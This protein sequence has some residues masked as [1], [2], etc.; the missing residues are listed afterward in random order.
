MK[1]RGARMNSKEKIHEKFFADIWKLQNFE[2][3]INDLLKSKE[4]KNLNELKVIKYV[5][6]I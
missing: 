3:E 1:T 2:K 5:F 4:Y 6:M